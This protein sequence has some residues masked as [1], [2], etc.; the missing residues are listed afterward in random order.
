MENDE[1]NAVVKKRLFQMKDE[2]YKKFQ[3]GL[4]PNLDKAFFI[5]VRT[6]ELRKLAK[7]IK[8]EKLAAD[9]MNELPHTYFEEN[10]LHAFLIAGIKDYDTCISELDRFLPYVDNWATCD[11]MNPKILKK[12]PDRLI[13][14]IHEWL[15][16]EKTYTIRFAIKL[17]MDFYLEDEFKEEY[18]ALVAE[19]SSE[20]Y[21]VKMM[22]AWYFATALSKQYD[23]VIPYIENHRLPEWTH[24]KTIQK[25]CESYRITPEQKT[26]LKKLK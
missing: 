20:E 3:S 17:L 9:F 7:E 4:T 25:A 13:N 16:S 12:Y 6:P 14:K 22:T 15:D 10:Q 2:Q 21:Y 19:I 23:S 18:P 26:Y 8:K 11:Q 1:I 24:R 5:G